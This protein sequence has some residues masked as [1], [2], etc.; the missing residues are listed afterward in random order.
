VTFRE[1]IWAAV[2]ERQKLIATEAFPGK[3][4]G[5]AAAELAKILGPSA[6][7][8]D[9]VFAVLEAAL[10]FGDRDCLIAYFDRR[11][12]PNA[13]E[14]LGMADKA[15]NVQLG[16]FDPLIR[17]IEEVKRLRDETGGGGSARAA[18]EEARV[19]VGEG[20]RRAV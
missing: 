17:G 18:R 8:G 5:P 13:E 11:L 2:V 10:R 12:R 14:L 9:A 1:A 3:E 19:E 16:L 6:D 15:I 4:A 20:I 7:R